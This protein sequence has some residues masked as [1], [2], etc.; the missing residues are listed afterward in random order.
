MSIDLHTHSTVSDGSLT[1][2]ELVALARRKGLSAL[3]I[4][5]HDSIEGIPEA[6]TAGAAMGVEVIPGLELSVSHG[7]LNMHLLGYF[8]E[9]ENKALAFALKRL[10]D[11]RALRNQTIIEKLNTLGIRIQKEEL[12]LVSGRGLCGRPHIARLLLEKGVVSTMD[13]AFEQYLGRDGSAYCSRFVYT[14]HGAIELLKE[15]GGVS[16]LA[17]PMQLSR[18]DDN[19]EPLLAELSCLGLDGIEV[20]YPTHSQ[21]Y[22][23]QLLA[24]VEKFN[25]LATGGSDYHG[26][27]RPGTTLAG[28]KKVTVPA[29]LLGKMKARVAGNREKQP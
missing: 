8:Y 6:L 15:A 3:S 25:L 19:L 13:E 20:F 26:S 11:G 12:Q 28:G 7:D 29:V 24:L 14:A 16:I 21:K 27:I 17:H 4:T 18:Y 22:R 1:P 5:D 10:Q 2:T 9:L 23:R